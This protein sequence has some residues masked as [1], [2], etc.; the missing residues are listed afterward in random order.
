[1]PQFSLEGQQTPEIKETI[2]K[3]LKTFEEKKANIKKYQIYLKIFEEKK[4]AVI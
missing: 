4:T 3:I 2:E 1:M